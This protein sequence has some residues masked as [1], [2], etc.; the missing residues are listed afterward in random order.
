MLFDFA[1]FLEKETKNDSI[2]FTIAFILKK[3]ATLFP[4]YFENIAQQS[5]NIL[6]L[7]FDSGIICTR[8]KHFQLFDVIHLMFK[9]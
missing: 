7:K 5:V 3:I 4:A 9:I 2:Y 6:T 8:K 1:K